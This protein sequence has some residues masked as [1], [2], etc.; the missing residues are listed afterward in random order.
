MTRRFWIG[1]VL[2][3]PVLVLE[4]GGLWRLILPIWLD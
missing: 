2:A 4:M 1:A 3:L